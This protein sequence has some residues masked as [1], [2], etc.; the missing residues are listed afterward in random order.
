MDRRPLQGQHRI[1]REDDQRDD[2][3]Q[4]ALVEGD[5][6]Q[7]GDIA[8]QQDDEHAAHRESHAEGLR[9]GEADAEDDQ[10][11][12][13]HDQGRRRLQQQ[14]VERLGMLQRPILQGVE[15]ADAGDRQHDHQAEFFADRGPVLGEMLPGERQHQQEGEGPAQERQRHRRDVA[16]GE[17]PHDRIA[18]PA[19]RGDA[20]QQIRLVGNPVLAGCVGARGLAGGGHCDCYGPAVE[21]AKATSPAASGPV[22]TRPRSKTRKSSLHQRGRAHRDHAA[23]D[24][25]PSALVE[26]GAWP[27]NISGFSGISKAWI[28]RWVFKKPRSCLPREAAS[29][30]RLAAPHTN[31]SRPGIGLGR[32]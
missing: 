28:G 1:E 15:G 22:E 9:R 32:I 3:D 2:E 8:V 21:C 19:Q 13:R 31:G 4:V 20:E 29:F 30:I 25:V 6:R 17:P 26:V 7:R 24:A 11:P 27:W 14:R 5:V 12:Q 10:R 16:G 18:G 23:A